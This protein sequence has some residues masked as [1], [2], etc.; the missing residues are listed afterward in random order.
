MSK[1]IEVRTAAKGDSRIPRAAVTSV[2]ADRVTLVQLR[3]EIDRLHGQRQRLHGE[4]IASG[5]RGDIQAIERRA[6]LLAR[7]V[8]R[9]L[10]C[11]D[12]FI[13]RRADETMPEKDT[14]G[15]IFPRY[16]F[17]EERRNARA[18]QALA[19]EQGV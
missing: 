19:R 16:D 8:S 1:S 3:E 6:M 13:E 15:R 14:Q 9:L 7:T 5:K 11:L 2:L 17:A 18:L 10:W 12:E 4:L